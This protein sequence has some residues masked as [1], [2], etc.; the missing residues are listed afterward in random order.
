MKIAYFNCSSGIAG[1]MILASLIDAGLSVKHLESVIKNGLKLGNWRLIT[2]ATDSLYHIPLKQLKVQGEKHFNS[3][4]SM[5]GLIKNSGLS[6]KAKVVSLK[7]L[8]LLISAE[9]SAHKIKKNQAHFHELNSLD[10]M[11]DVVGVSIAL[12][13]LGIDEV[14]S[15]F[16]NI[17]KPAP[18][19]L[20]MIKERKLPVYS[21]N[22]VLELATPTGI[23]IISNISKGFGDMPLIRLERSGMGAG[24]IKAANNY[25]AV[26][27]GEAQNTKKQLTYYGQDEVILLDTNIDDM[28]PRIFPYLI[29]KLLT[30]GAKDAWL[31]QVLMKKGRPGIVLSVMC[32]REKEKTIVDTIFNETTT[33]GIRRQENKRYILKRKRINDIKIAFLK[34]GK[35]KSNLEFEVAKKKSIARKIPLKNILL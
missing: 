27:I 23:A 17:G 10:T 6:S 8:S 31:E 9:A 32:E 4:G 7:I 5:L 1:D 21:N 2:K 26:M 3:P 35:V 13:L 11:I 16:I 15:S 18:A 33:L 34:N 28:D 19:S 14:Y 24:T 29:D 25:L 30:L 20:A 22:S 12:D